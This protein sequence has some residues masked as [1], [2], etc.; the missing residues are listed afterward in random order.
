VRGRGLAATGREAEIAGEARRAV[1]GLPAGERQAPAVEAAVAGAVRR[2]FRREGGQRP[3]V[4][5]AVLEA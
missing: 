5:V 1:E 2:W 4:E 3:A